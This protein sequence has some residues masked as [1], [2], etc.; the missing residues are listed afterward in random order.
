MPGG[1]PAYVNYG[2]LTTC[3]SPVDCMGSTLYAFFLDVDPVCTQAL[4]RRVFDEPSEGDVKVHPLLDL[5]M[6]TFGSVERVKPQLPPWSEMGYASERQVA[7]WIPVLVRRGIIP[8]VGWFVPYMWVDNPVSLTGGREIYGFNKSWGWIGLPG[9]GGTFTLDAYGG[10]YDPEQ[11][12]GRKPLLQVTSASGAL[13]LGAER[14][15]GLDEVLGAAQDV[16]AVNEEIEPAEDF[17]PDPRG[18]L[19]DTMLRLGGA[20]QFYLRQFRSIEDCVRSDPQQVTKSGVT[21]KAIE[22]SRLQSVF[23]FEL[24]HLDSHPVA[25]EI[26]VGNQ[27]TSRAFEMKMDFTLEDGSVIW[28]P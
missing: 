6:L 15:Q 5:V 8:E 4:C 9:A 1:L 18:E 24:S 19:F 16:L 21:V 2:G 20:P 27:S 25:A 17:G 11:P 22:M 14:W 23:T 13:T 10:N 28:P 12:A 3:P 7:F 26:G